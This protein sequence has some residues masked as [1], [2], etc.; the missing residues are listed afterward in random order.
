MLDNIYVTGSATV[1]FLTTAGAYQPNFAGGAY[2]PA[3]NAFLAKID[4]NLSGSASLLYG[5]YLGGSLNDFGYN[6]GNAGEDVGT[7]IAV[8]ASDNA[9]IVG[10]TYSTNFPTTAGAFQKNNGGGLDVFVAKFNPSL[11]G[12]ASLVYSTYLGGSG[13]DGYWTDYPSQLSVV[14]PGPGIAVD[15]AGDAYVA[16][17][18]TSTNFPTTPGAFQTTYKG[19][20]LGYSAGDAFVTKLNA[21]GSGLVYLTYLGGS[22]EDGATAVAVDASGNAY[23]TG[24]TRSTDFPTMNPIQAQKASGVDS[25]GFANSDVFVTTLNSSGNGLLFSTYFGGAGGSISKKGVFTGSN[26]DEYGYAI[27]LDSAG[28]IYVTGSTSAGGEAIST[29]FPTTP[30]AFQTTPGSGFVFKISSPTG[31]QLASPLTTSL[32]SGAPVIL[33]GA[34]GG[35]LSAPSPSAAHPQ[36]A[37]AATRKGPDV[38][39]TD[40]S[41]LLT[42]GGTFGDWQSDQEA[43]AAGWSPSD[44]AFRR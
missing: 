8:D 14:E 3:Q 12:A 36:T 1:G 37:T 19:G 20:N 7:G 44:L 34:S 9:Y 6:G 31:S 22:N 39:Q 4:P 15:A 33:T 18:T 26:G 42:D 38:F 24:W 41:N 28:N 32:S 30:G 27:A 29:N 23:V 25:Q 10:R 16:G 13:S 21:A 2:A 43:V 40:L 5:T 35:G 17:V 11:S